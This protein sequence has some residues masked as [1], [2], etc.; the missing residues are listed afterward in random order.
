MILSQAS[1][2]LPSSLMDQPFTYKKALQAGLSRYAFQKL[3]EN[4]DIEKIARGIY[5]SAQFDFSEDDQLIAATL[6]TG[7]P[8]AI[9]LLTAAAYYDLTDEIPNKVWIMVP[10]TKVLHAR[11]L[12]LVRTRHPHWDIG[13]THKQGFR[14]TTLERSIVDCLTHRRQLGSRIGIDA[15]RTAL[16]TKKTSLKEVYRIA[17]ALGVGDQI[18]PYIEVLA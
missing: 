18:L 5:R 9:C 10:F 6:K 4:G 17:L 2:S 13:I 16:D 11:E 12:R 14:I 1:T 7:Q 3:L 15:L 8:S